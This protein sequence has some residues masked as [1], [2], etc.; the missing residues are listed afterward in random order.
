MT[1][2]LLAPEFRKNPYPVFAQLRLNDAVYWSD[3][4]QA[5]LVTPYEQVSLVFQMIVFQQI[6]SSQECISFLQITKTGS[7]PFLMYYRCGH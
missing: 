2:D 7:N 6:G 4:I 1:Y 5:W 3:Q